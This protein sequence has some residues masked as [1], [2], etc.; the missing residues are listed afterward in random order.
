MFCAPQRTTFYSYTGSQTRP[1]YF[2]LS[3]TLLWGIRADLQS[4]FHKAC[5]YKMKWHMQL[6]GHC[7]SPQSSSLRFFPQSHGIRHTQKNF[8]F[9]LPS[10]YLIELDT[11]LKQSA[12]IPQNSYRYWLIIVL[13]NNWVA[14]T[15]DFRHHDVQILP[16]NNVHQRRLVKFISNKTIPKLIPGFIF[17]HMDL[18]WRFKKSSSIPSVVQNPSYSRL[19]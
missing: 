19:T 3:A 13:K 16:Q 8:F 1:E 4:P 14:G 2:V 12:A 7:L 15:R 18:I 5:I 6:K 10:N 9:F 11:S 17:Q